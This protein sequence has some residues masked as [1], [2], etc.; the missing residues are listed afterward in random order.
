MLADNVIVNT[1]AYRVMGAVR[2]MPGAWQFRCACLPNPVRLAIV[3]IMWIRA[4]SIVSDSQNMPPVS[5]YPVSDPSVTPPEGVAM[6]E[7]IQDIHK[8][9]PTRDAQATPQPGAAPQPELEGSRPPHKQK[10][11]RLPKGDKFM[12]KVSLA[13]IRTCRKKS[14]DK[15]NDILL[16]CI[17]RKKGRILEDIADRT[18][19]PKSTVS[20]RLRRMH[21]EGLEGRY[22]RPKSGRPRKLDPNLEK[23]VKRAITCKDTQSCTPVHGLRDLKPIRKPGASDMD[24]GVWTADIISDMLESGFGMVGMSHSSIYSMLHRLRLSNH[25]IGRPVHPKAPSKR[26]KTWYKKGLARRVIKWTADGYTV[27]YMDESYLNTKPN[28]GRTW[29]PIGSKAEQPLPARGKR[30]DLYGALGDGVSYII[31]T[32]SDI[33]SDC[34]RSS[35]TCSAL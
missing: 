14:D 26:K 23:H 3:G 24:S 16:M 33:S 7:Y 4:L 1:G 25:L 9:R 19:T 30:I 28:P 21:K 29:C 18:D 13:E 11:W 17:H 2:S 20:N 15:A 8:P 31:L 6:P 12:P 34:A 27:L 35:T 10:R 5:N 32:A 22:H